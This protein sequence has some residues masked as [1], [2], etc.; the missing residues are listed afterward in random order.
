M[1]N[2]ITPESALIKLNRIR[3]DK[4]E[5]PP[6][7]DMAIKAI[8]RQFVKR[9]P[10]PETRYYGNGRCPNCDAVFMDKSTRFCGNCGQALDW[11]E[12]GSIARSN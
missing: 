10:K 7:I 4:G 2:N 5:R 1:P 9:K 11:G 6:E 3:T 12:G 8:N